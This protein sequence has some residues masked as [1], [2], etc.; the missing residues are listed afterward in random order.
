M[1][2]I[3]ILIVK[4]ATISRQSIN[5]HRSIKDLKNFG[6]MLCLL[7]GNQ[8]LLCNHGTMAMP[9]QHVKGHFPIFAT[10]NKRNPIQS[11]KMPAERP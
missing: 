6:I 10:K 8:G 5:D 11:Q 1:V 9:T 2:T 7:T 3:I 4:P